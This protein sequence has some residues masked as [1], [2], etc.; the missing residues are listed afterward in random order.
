MEGQGLRKCRNNNSVSLL[1]TLHNNSAARASIANTQS[2]KYIHELSKHTE[3]ESPCLFLQ[4]Q[5][6]KAEG[7]AYPVL[8][9]EIGL[10]SRQ[11]QGHELDEYAEAIISQVEWA[12][13]E[14]FSDEAG[15][16]EQMVVIANCAGA[17]SMQARQIS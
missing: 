11:C 10:A 4:L 1:H 8:K 2:L 14:H 16:P 13:H 7:V 3:F 6:V 5:W 15:Y 12:M 17:S 9:I